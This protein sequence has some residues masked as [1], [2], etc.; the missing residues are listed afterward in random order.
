[1]AKT[2]GR[3]RYDQEDRGAAEAFKK[4]G[5]KLVLDRDDARPLWV[6]LRNRIE[7][8][9]NTGLVAA[10]SRIP[11]EQALCEF[12]GISRPVVRA[13]LGALSSNGRVVKIPRKGMFVAPPREQVDFMG[14][15]LGVFDDLT[16]KGH[17]VS[18]RTFEFF[19]CPPNEKECR[20][21]GIPRE[22]SVVRIGRV[23]L[24]DGVP[25]T[26]T[27]ISLPGHKVPG[28]ESL[29]IENRSIFQTIRAQYGLTV[30]RAERWFTAAL[31]TKEESERMGVPPNTPLISIE[32][33]AYDA[34]GAPLEYYQ[35][36]YNSSLARIHVAINSEAPGVAVNGTKAV[37][38]T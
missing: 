13:A 20:V 9:I 37:R 34:E 16:A 26:L 36:L 7:E 21:F 23:Y 12:F 27:H 1:M 8:A 33:I 28:M 24:S 15:N 31:P 25:I 38:R 32:S 29:K 4:I 19:R 18:T 6:Q 22:G 2:R 35:A 17:V 5:K 10:N 11:S 3:P 30:Q 14:A